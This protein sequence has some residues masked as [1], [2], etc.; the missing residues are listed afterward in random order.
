M[1]TIKCNDNG[2]KPLTYILFNASPSQD[3]IATIPYILNAISLT[4]K[5]V[6]CQYSKMA[7]TFSQSNFLTR[8]PVIYTHLKYF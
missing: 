5:N 1:Y 6:T 4:E 8:L 2:K 7:E 3:G